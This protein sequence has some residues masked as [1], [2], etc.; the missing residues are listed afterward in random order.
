MTY[1]ITVESVMSG[2][3]IWDFHGGQGT[4]FGHLGIERHNPEDQPPYTECAVLIII[5]L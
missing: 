1:H 4:Y 2:H 5:L 3:K